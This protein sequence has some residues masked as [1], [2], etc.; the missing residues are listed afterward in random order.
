MIKRHHKVDRLYL[1]YGSNLNKRGMAMR[2]MDAQPVGKFLITNARLVFRG[3][4]DIEYFEGAQVPVG[5]WKI[6]ARDEAAL[7]RYEGVKAGFYRKL[8]FP[9]EDTTAL[10]YIMRR[11]GVAPPS[12]AYYDSIDQGYRDFGFDHAYLRAALE[13]SYI[14][15]DV[16][17]HIV[18]RR[19]RD[20]LKIARAPIM[21]EAARYE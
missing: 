17:E 14:D 16:V 3:V 1:A 18:Q 9:L 6:S 7:D 4:A 5:V 19:K 2:T 12:Q 11:L 15:K 8:A 21:M 20:G 10:V 13:H